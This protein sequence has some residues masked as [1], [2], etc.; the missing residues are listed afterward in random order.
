MITD[1]HQTP[2]SPIF[3][4]CDLSTQITLLFNLTIEL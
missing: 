1:Y 3:C 2:F 4:I